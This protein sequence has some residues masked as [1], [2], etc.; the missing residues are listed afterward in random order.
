MLIAGL[1]GSRDIYRVGFGMPLAEIGAAWIKAIGLA[2]EPQP[3]SKTRR[4][5][6]S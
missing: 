5:R 4:A 3:S 6:R 1:A 2:V